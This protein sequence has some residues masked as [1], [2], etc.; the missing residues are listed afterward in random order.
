MSKVTILC[1]LQEV[2]TGFLVNAY[3]GGTIEDLKDPMMLE[4]KR[5]FVKM[6]STLACEVF[7][8]TIELI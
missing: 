1:F 2:E 3:A 4:K 8:P 7:I 5:F 6:M